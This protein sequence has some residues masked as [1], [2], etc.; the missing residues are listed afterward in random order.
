VGELQI[1]VSFGEG[2][3]RVI[4][5]DE[6]YRSACQNKGSYPGIKMM[7]VTLASP[8]VHKWKGNKRKKGKSSPHEREGDSQ[9]LQKI[10]KYQKRKWLG[11]ERGRWENSNAES[12]NPGEHEIK[13]SEMLP[14]LSGIG[15]KQRRL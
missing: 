14:S 10:S 12:P 4:R 15:V 13:S 5:N 6:K 9:H 7:G 3:E 8:M 2:G 11:E 1:A